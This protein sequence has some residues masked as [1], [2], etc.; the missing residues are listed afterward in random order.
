MSIRADTM[1]IDRMQQFICRNWGNMTVSMI[2][3][4]LL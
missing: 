2:T 3:L 4:A 1:A